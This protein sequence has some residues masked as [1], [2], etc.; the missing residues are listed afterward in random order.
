MRHSISIP[1]PN[2]GGLSRVGTSRLLNIAC[3]PATVA[4]H[5]NC[6]LARRFRIQLQPTV[7][8]KGITREDAEATRAAPVRG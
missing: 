8:W 2:A 4:G 7:G 1:R 3:E 5:M 6:T